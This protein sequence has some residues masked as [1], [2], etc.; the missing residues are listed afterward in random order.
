M[1]ITVELASQFDS[2]I[3]FFAQIDILDEIELSILLREFLELLRSRDG[4]DKLW[5]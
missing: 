5:G 3:P 1:S 4:Y 2:L